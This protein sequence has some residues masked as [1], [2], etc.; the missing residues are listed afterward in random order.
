ML[1]SNA[2]TVR[3]CDN[4]CDLT[5]LKKKLKIKGLK[6][7]NRNVNR[8]FS[9]NHKSLENC[10]YSMTDCRDCTNPYHKFSGS[11]R[12]KTKWCAQLLLIF[13]YTFL[14]ES[15]V[16]IGAFSNSNPS[17]Y[18]VTIDDYSSSIN[19]NKN[20][21]DSVSYK[22]T[23]PV[24]QNEFAVYIPKGIEKAFEIADKH[25]FSNMG[26]VRITSKLFFKR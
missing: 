24:Y 2:R 14:L 19:Y 6:C 5:K 4:K 10:Q 3:Q 7:I 9:N 1:S 23:P 20:Y 26:Q 11:I 18:N 16:V 12:R 8:N 21:S 22:R 25:G 15:N 17:N 13:I